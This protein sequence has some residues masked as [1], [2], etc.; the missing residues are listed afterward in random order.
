V[1]PCF[2]GRF[3][4]PPNVQKEKVMSEPTPAKET[5]PETKTAKLIRLILIWVVLGLVLF[6]GVMAAIRKFG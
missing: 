2:A 1:P 4:R 6:T 5:K 3:S